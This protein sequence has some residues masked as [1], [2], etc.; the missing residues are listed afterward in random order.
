MRWQ[1]LRGNRCRHRQ[2]FR[3]QSR[4][5]HRLSSA[6][7]KSKMP[8]GLNKQR[9][10]G[11]FC[12]QALALWLRLPRTSKAGWRPPLLVESLCPL[13]LLPLISMRQ[14]PD[15]SASPIHSFQC[16]QRH[17]ACLAFP[18]HV[19]ALCRTTTQYSFPARL[20]RILPQF[21]PVCAAHPP[22]YNSKMAGKPNAS[23]AAPVSLP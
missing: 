10:A 21:P 4:V 2:I 1:R 6:R 12:R 22:L 3:L 14:R 5:L 20:C 16:R 17:S 11:Q 23:W 8:S 15:S 7:S 18:L 19:Q 9:P 13:F